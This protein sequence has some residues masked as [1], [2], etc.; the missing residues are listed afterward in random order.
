M[1]IFTPET[2]PMF[3]RNVLTAVFSLLSAL[4]MT[5]APGWAM[6]AGGPSYLDNGTC[7]LNPH[8]GC[9]IGKWS[10]SSDFDMPESMLKGNFARSNGKFR[11]YWPENS[12]FTMLMRSQGIL[13]GKGYKVDLTD[14]I[15]V[16]VNMVIQNASTLQK[17]NATCSGTL[18]L[19]TRRYLQSVGR[20]NG[21]TCDIPINYFPSNIYISTDKND[22]ATATLSMANMGSEERSIEIPA[23]SIMYDIEGYSSC[24]HG[25]C[26]GDSSIFTLPYKFIEISKIKLNDRVCKVI[27]PKEV[28]F[29]TIESLANGKISE[30]EMSLDIQCSGYSSNSQRI[31]GVGI[32]N[33]ILGV[34][35]RSASEFYPMDKK[36]ETIGL[37]TNGKLRDDLYVDGSFSQGKA[38]GTDAL[39]TNSTTN[40]FDSPLDV[41]KTDKDI[42]VSPNQQPKIYWR[43][44]SGTNGSLEPGKFEGQAYIDVEYK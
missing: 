38:C 37:K 39:K 15:K 30:K 13:S 33:Q 14:D 23:V 35:I 10:V 34:K 21:I 5:V 42:T 27:T 20:N 25:N 43:L 11:V 31:S 2:K 4:C 19:G 26:I 22:K 7:L 6:A 17:K 44:C 28:N 12:E 18:Y 16:T 9:F 32:S 40:Q 36:N 41:A 3:T 1:V 24:S 29:G 8:D